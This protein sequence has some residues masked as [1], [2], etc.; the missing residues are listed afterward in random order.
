M[1]KPSLH[2]DKVAESRALLDERICRLICPIASGMVGVC[3]T[4]IGV[5]HVAFTVHGRQT[6][7]D[8]LLSIDALIFLLAT[9]SSYFALRVQSQARMHWLERVADG[10]FIASMVLLTIACFV[11]TYSLD[12]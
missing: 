10:T 5:L 9:L 2:D 4:G 11:I 6:L 7:A 1:S 3:M 8:D 12:G